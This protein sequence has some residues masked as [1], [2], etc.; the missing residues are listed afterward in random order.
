VQDLSVE[1]GASVAVASP[2]SLVADYDRQPCK[3]QA[4]CATLAQWPCTHAPGIPDRRDRF[5]NLA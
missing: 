5:N 2:R 3:R 1:P 4:R